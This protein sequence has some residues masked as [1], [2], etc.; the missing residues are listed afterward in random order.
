MVDQLDRAIVAV[1]KLGREGRLTIIPDEPEPERRVNDVWKCKFDGCDR[2]F[3]SEQRLAGHTGQHMTASRRE[4]Q[5]KRFA[6]AY[7]AADN[8]FGCFRC[9]LRFKTSKERNDHM[10]AH[11]AEDLAR[12]AENATKRADEA[13][14]RAAGEKYAASIGIQPHD[15]YAYI[16]PEYDPPLTA[17]PP[18]HNGMVPTGLPKRPL[19]HDKIRAAAWAD[20]EDEVKNV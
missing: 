11:A 8:P 20:P 14:L 13:D 4:A 16:P 5:A 17:G 10:G 6:A 18:A 19:D 7:N 15:G 2:S 9:T 3:P 1:E 12:A